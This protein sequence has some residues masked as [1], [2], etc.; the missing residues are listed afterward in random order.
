MRGD[1]A[2]V[3][4]VGDADVAFAIVGDPVDD[5]G[6]VESEIPGRAELCGEAKVRPSGVSSPQEKS[7]VSLTKVECAVRIRAKAMPPPP[8]AA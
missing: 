6:V 2:A 1:E 7:S 3:R 5:R 4:I 8:Q